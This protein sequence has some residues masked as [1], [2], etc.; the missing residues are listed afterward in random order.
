MEGLYRL[1][2]PVSTD[3]YSHPFGYV[4]GWVPQIPTYLIENWT[5]EVARSVVKPPQPPTVHFQETPQKTE[6]SESEPEASPTTRSK[7][8][9]KGKK[10]EKKAVR[11]LIWLQSNPDELPLD[12]PGQEVAVDEDGNALPRPNSFREYLLPEEKR[13]FSVLDR[14]ETVLAPTHLLPPFGLKPRSEVRRPHKSDSHPKIKPPQ[15]L[16]VY[17]KGP[18]FKQGH[19]L[20]ELTTPL[21]NDFDPPNWVRFSTFQVT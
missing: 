14:P 11:P 20:K 4:P 12:L 8:K 2:T 5:R 21:F 19:L 9:G 10:K 3:S 18:L 1:P 16:P 6:A 15:K 7:A 13:T 17:D